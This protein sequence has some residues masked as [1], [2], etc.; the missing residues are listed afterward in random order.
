MRILI[1]AA[2]IALAP[3]AV[4]VLTSAPAHAC[5]NYYFDQTTRTTRCGDEPY[6]GP[7]ATCSND[8]Y[9]T[10]PKCTNPCSK[11]GSDKN[12][13]NWPLGCDPSQPMTK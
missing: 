11:S 5:Q 10:L 8:W 6:T 12:G 13:V 1:A 4:S 2:A 3:Y 9:S 7:A